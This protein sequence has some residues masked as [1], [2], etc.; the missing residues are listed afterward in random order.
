MAVVVDTDVV[1][2]FFKNDSRR[3][4]YEP[5][6]RGQFMFV[7]F[8]T[9][10]ELQNWA[11]RSNWGKRKEADFAKYLRRYS[12]QHSTPELCRLWAQITDDGRRQ[13]KVIAVADAWIAATALYF[14]VPL[15]THNGDDFR[16]VNGL[17]IISEQ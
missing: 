14:G 6:L 9:L 12:I 17:N 4:L 8:M 16:Y 15:V 7:S 10:A 13:G 5:H 3:A 2:Y 11:L 1:S